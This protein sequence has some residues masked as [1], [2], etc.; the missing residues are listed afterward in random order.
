MGEKVIEKLILQLITC[1]LFAFVYLVSAAIG[2]WLWGM[3]MVEVFGLPN[4]T[5]WQMYGLMWLVRLL[6]PNHSRINSDD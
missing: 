4:L 3:V 6:I 2:L 1:I 5:F